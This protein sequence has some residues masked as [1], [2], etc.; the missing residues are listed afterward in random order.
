MAWFAV[1]ISFVCTY[2]Y[3]PTPM[4][5]VKRPDLSSVDAAHWS[6]S[7]SVAPLLRSCLVFFVVA[8]VVCVEL[9]VA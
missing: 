7:L 3:I 8:F 2:I 4:L 6:S 5:S 1:T 9:I